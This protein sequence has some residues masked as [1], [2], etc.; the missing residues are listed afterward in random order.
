MINHKSKTKKIKMGRK[1][2]SAF[3]IH[4]QTTCFA[5]GKYLYV[6]KNDFVSEFGI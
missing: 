3:L 2:D 6:A 4:F 5:Y 1:I